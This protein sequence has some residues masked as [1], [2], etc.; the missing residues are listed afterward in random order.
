MC[1]T[2]DVAR[3]QRKMATQE[4]RVKGSGAE[5]VDSGLQVQLEKDVRRRQHGTE[6][7]RVDVARGRG[8]VEWSLACGALGAT[9]H[10]VIIGTV[11]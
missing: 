1:A 8:R 4:H 7:S 6:L 3:P 5:D 10:Q 9:R 11:Q 2:V